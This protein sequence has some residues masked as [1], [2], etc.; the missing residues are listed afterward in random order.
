[1]AI[2]PVLGDYLISI[3]HWC[4]NAVEATDGL[5]AD[6]FLS[7]KLRQMALSMC[8]VQ[9]GEASGRILRK[10]PEFASINP[11]IEL[12]KAHAMR[13]RIV[14]GYEQSDMMTLW[15]TVSV[16]IPVMRAEVYKLLIE[17]GVE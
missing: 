6:Q 13:H 1:M 4:G 10:W 2:D 9:I 7:V 16:S 12:A 14:H 15:F 17:H 8:V 3:E 5:T 11:Q